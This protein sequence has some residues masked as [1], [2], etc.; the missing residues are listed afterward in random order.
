MRNI[1][2]GLAA[3]A[4]ALGLATAAA[5]DAGGPYKLDAKGKCHDVKGAFAKAE[6]CKAPA[7]AKHCRDMKTKKFAKCGMP[8]TEPVPSK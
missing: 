2:T 8:G 1:L 3:C 7:A 4:I 6:M 5:A